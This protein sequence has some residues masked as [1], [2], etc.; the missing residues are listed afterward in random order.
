[1]QAAENTR[2]LSPEEFER[3]RVAFGRVMR[4]EYNDLVVNFIKLLNN[5][6]SFGFNVQERFTPVGTTRKYKVVQYMLNQFGAAK[7]EQALTEFALQHPNRVNPKRRG[8]QSW[9]GTPQRASQAARVEIENVPMPEEEAA[10][11]VQ[12]EPEVMPVVPEPEPVTLEGLHHKQ[13]PVLLRLLKVRDH[14]NYTFPIWIPGPAGSGKTTAAMNAA[15]EMGHAFY[16]TGAVGNQ[17]ELLGFRDATGTYNETEFYKAYKDGGVFL[18]DEV[19]ASN[20]QALVCFNAALENGHCA[21]PNGTVERHADFIPI[22]AANTYGAGATHE[23]VGRNKLDAAT[24]DRFIMLDWQYDEALEL[25]LARNNVWVSTV[26]KVRNAVAA[27]GIKH[28]VSPRASIRGAK[29]LAAGFT[30]TQA[31]DMAVRKGLTAD[32]W[33]QV[34]ARAGV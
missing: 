20:P 6:Q 30:V 9:K 3:A 27:C 23:Y 1:M 32:Q 14:N 34:K 25:A 12:P 16:H 21:F 8:K 2:Q 29:L 11:V 7:V 10:P 15:K 26:H 18:W 5:G 19:D 28:V 31:L 17:Y 24:V 13:F 4:L 33:Q 22:A